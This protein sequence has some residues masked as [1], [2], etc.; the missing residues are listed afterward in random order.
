MRYLPPEVLSNPRLIGRKRFSV[1]VRQLCASK[2]RA[3]RAG[4]FFA[5][6]FELHAGVS[7][8]SVNVAVA[9]CSGPLSPPSSA[10]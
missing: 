8:R 9:T 1:S 6:L 10:R 3:S 7:G 2:Q 5:P 4:G